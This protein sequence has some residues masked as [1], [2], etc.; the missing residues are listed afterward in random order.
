MGA[1]MIVVRAL[2]RSP[3]AARETNA[4]RCRVR[5]GRA[6]AV[7]PGRARRVKRDL[8]AA[9]GEKA[10]VAL[11]PKALLGPRAEDPATP[12]GPRPRR[13]SRRPAGRPPPRARAAREG[14][15]H[16]GS[17]GRG[18]APVVVGGAADLPSKPRAGIGLAH[19]FRFW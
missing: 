9:G 2:L 14:L 18:I 6:A 11:A 17:R 4:A 13:V 8:A 19:G 12:K 16:R 7:R 10:A 15:R 5:K 3:E 1:A